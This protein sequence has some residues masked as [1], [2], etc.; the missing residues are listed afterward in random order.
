MEVT[1]SASACYFLFIIWLL[2]NI[3]IIYTVLD[4]AD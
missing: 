4:G 1:L 3:G 2:I